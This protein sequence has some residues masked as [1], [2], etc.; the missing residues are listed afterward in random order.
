MNDD[1]ER[2]L[3]PFG[4]DAAGAPDLSP[5][6]QRCAETLYRQAWREYRSVGRPFG[7]TDEAM[8]VWYALHGSSPGPTHVTGRN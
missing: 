6:L 3:L 8:L 1:Y 4:P 2:S 5:S 7:D